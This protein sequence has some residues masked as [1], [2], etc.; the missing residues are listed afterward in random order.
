MALALLAAMIL[1]YELL[2]W[3]RDPAAAHELR[4]SLDDAIPFRAASVFAYSWVYTSM[5][6]PAFVIRSEALF[7]RVATAYGLVL[8][9]SLTC[10]AAWPVTSLGL[11]P[12]VD[13]IDA[14]T[15]AGWAVRLT[16]RIDPPYNLFPSLHLSI[17]TLAA[18]CA[19]TA[20]RLYGLLAM[21]VVAGIAVSICTM[22]QHFVVDGL[23]AIPL[24][25][26]AW[27]LVIRPFNRDRPPDDEVALGWRG[28]AAYLAFHALFY[29]AAWGVFRS[30]LLPV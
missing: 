8:A 30:G 5:L 3:T 7:R 19:W 17:A 18:L 14:S 6:F 26:L 20:R 15:F 16:Y 22:K 25:V 4:T 24:A 9:V 1:G 28:P 27:A 12:P 23:D 2:G 29:G 10:F 13:S 11:R 21:P